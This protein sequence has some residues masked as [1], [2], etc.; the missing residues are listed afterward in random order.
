LGERTAK[1]LNRIAKNRPRT[2]MPLRGE[3]SF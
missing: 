3:S 2:P 1:G